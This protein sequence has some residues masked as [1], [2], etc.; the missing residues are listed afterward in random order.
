MISLLHRWIFGAQNQAVIDLPGYGIID[1]Q[2]CHKFLRNSYALSLMTHLE[3][4]H[5]MHEDIAH[6]TAVRMLDILYAQRKRAR[7]L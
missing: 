3:R 5:E 6:D 2:R 4:D 1:C 7:S